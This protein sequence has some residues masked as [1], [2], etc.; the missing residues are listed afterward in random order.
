MTL[1][2]M[3][4]TLILPTLITIVWWGVIPIL[5]DPSPFMSHLLSLTLPSAAVV[6][7]VAIF[8]FTWE[9]IKPSKSPKTDQEKQ[10]EH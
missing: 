4:L 8:L 10:P 9:M 7:S 6:S 5:K 1:S 3:A 2:V